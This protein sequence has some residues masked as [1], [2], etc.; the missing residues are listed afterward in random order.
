MRGGPGQF[1]ADLRV[2]DEPVGFPDIMGV[3]GSMVHQRFD[4]IRLKDNGPRLLDSEFR[5]FDEIGE[6]RFPEGAIF[7]F[8]R[9]RAGQF[10]ETLRR[11]S[12]LERCEERRS[13]GVVPH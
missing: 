5:A 13:L 9:G 11:Q 1:G 2:R 4:R 6:I 10:H 12:G 3:R 7:E 8:R